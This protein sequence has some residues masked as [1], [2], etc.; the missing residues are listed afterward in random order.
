MA[1]L[2]CLM[3]CVNDRH[4]PGFSTQHLTS[5]SSLCGSL[6]SLRLRNIAPH[7]SVDGQLA[8]REEDYAFVSCLTAL[9]ALMMPMVS[10]R[11]NLAAISHCTALRE[12]R[13]E[14]PAGNGQTH[15]QVEECAA[16]QQ[17]VHLTCLCLP[18]ARSAHTA[19]EAEALTSALRSLQ[20]LQVLQAYALDL[21]TLPGLASLT[22]LTK[23]IGSWREEQQQ[24]ET[25]HA[26]VTCSS[27]QVLSLANSAAVPYKAFP[28]IK[29][30]T[31]HQPF[32]AEQ[33]LALVPN[34]W[35]HLTSLTLPAGYTVQPTAKFTPFFSLSSEAPVSQRAAAIRGLAAL[36]QLC[37]LQFAANDDAEV[38]AVASLKQ[39][40]QLTLCVPEGSQV[41]AMGLAALVRLSQLQELMYHIRPLLIL[42]SDQISLLLCILEGVS[43]VRFRVHE[44]QQDIITDVLS[45]CRA[46]DLALPGSVLFLTL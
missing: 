34:C 30:M 3:V 5:L 46:S 13:L 21:R 1:Q 36:H 28:G 43:K 27:V 42:Q 37:S 38:A 40:R 9:T 4:W 7:T 6:R 8:P 44:V 32:Q 15:V 18:R 29:S 22:S 12:L 19:E 11:R 39:L 20:M 45:S 25:W 33:L 23:L 16:L 31:M 17:L 10:T 24:L 14:G 26:D 41:T 35:Q 2:T